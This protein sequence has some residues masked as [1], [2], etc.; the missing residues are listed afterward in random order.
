VERLM[1]EYVGSAVRKEL[2]YAGITKDD[3]GVE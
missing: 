1:V 3:V 2:E